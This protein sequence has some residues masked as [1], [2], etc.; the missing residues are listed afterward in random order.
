MHSDRFTDEQRRYFRDADGAHFRFQTGGGPVADAEARLLAA[1]TVE[2]G[3]RLL[4]VGCG[5]GGNLHHLAG[6]GARRFGVDFSLAKARFAQQATAA[7]CAAADATRLPFRDGVFDAVLIRDL[8][9]HLPDRLAALREA[10]RVLRPGGRLTLIEPNRYSPLI[11]A[12]ATLLPA[13]RGV[14]AS[15]GPRLVGEV[16]AAGFVGL[17]LEAAQPLPLSRLLCHPMLPLAGLAGHPAFARL[18]GAVEERLAVL[19]TW[20]WMYLVVHGEKP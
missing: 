11:L 16:A 9:H 12:Q 20:S 5:E 18:I 2:P 1:V 4:E 14:L 13:E 17:G 3:E 7:P 10:R 8:L 19:P 6:R 15:H